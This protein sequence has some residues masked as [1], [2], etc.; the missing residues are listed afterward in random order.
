[1]TETSRRSC[2]TDWTMR[3]AIAAMAAGLGSPFEVTGAAHLPSAIERVPKTLLRLEGFAASI[4][5]RIGELR[6]LLARFWRRRRHRGRDRRCACGALS[7]T[8]P[9]WPN[10]GTSAVWRISIAPSQGRR[11]RWPAHGCP[12]ASATSS[13][14]AAASS[15]LPRPQPEDAGA[16]VIRAALAGT[17]RPRDADPRPVRNPRVRAGVRAPVRRR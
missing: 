7:A 16:S 2:C 4:D 3:R 14:G 17:G 5:Y 8:R 1:M 12:V 10:H 6:K 11:A 15:G 9:F 13:I